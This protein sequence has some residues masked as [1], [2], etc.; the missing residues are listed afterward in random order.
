MQFN[1]QF[2]LIICE[3]ER[4]SLLYHSFIVHHVYEKENIFL[5]EKLA[6]F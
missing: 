2:N 1:L 3:V 5:F 4:K 6:D